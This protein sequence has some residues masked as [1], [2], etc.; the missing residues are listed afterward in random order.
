MGPLLAELARV[1][2]GPLEV[3]VSDDA[4]KETEY[5]EIDL[6]T[7]EDTEGHPGE[8]S[9]FGCPDCGGSLRVVRE[10]ELE[11]YRCRVGHAWRVKRRWRD[12]AKRSTARLWTALRALEESASLSRRMAS[13]AKGRGNAMLAERF[14]GNAT[15]AEHRASIILGVLLQN[16]SVSVSR[17]GAMTKSDRAAIAGGE[18]ERRANG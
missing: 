14:M 2:A 18:K 17:T 6:E 1:P 8:L 9:M 3:A 10:G 16:Q 7:I 11:R 5:A 15:D 12:K 13:R 4:R